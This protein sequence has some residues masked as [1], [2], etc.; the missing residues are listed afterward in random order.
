MRGWV[1]KAK[2]KIE[3]R[4]TNTKYVCKRPHGHQFYKLY[5]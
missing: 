3:E 4:K 1:G 2:E 5:E